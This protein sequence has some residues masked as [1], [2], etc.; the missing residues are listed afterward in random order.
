MDQ[1][2]QTTGQRATSRTTINS[3]AHPK[4]TD[5]T[6]VQSLAVD[7]DQPHQR[8]QLEDNGQVSLNGGGQ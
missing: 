5:F 1:Q 4:S 6:A 7:L 2:I 3:S 8:K